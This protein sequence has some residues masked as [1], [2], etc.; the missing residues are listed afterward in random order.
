M[1]TASSGTA[2]GDASGRVQA[3]PSASAVVLG[4]V[5]MLGL[6]LDLPGDLL[7]E[8]LLTGSDDAAQ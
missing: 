4:G 3:I 5:E 7:A 6:P 8:C 2:S 1:R